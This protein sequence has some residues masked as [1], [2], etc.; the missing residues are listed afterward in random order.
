VRARRGQ[1][2]HTGLERIVPSAASGGSVGRS[3]PAGRSPGRGSEA[4]GGRFELPTRRVTGNGFRD[5][6]IRPLCHPSEL[7]EKRLYLLPRPASPTLKEVRPP[8]PTWRARLTNA[9]PRLLLLL[10]AE[11]RHASQREADFWRKRSDR[12]GG[13][14]PL[15]LSLERTDASRHGAEGAGLAPVTRLTRPT[16]I[17][18]PLGCRRGSRGGD[19]LRQ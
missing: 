12:Y 15:R 10:T 9:V 2:F 6:R 1:C 18:N 7:I 8:R 16:S 11:S 13:R 4:E 14:D 17:W 5:R 19:R 3:R